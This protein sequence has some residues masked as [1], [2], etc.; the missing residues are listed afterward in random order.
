M[1]PSVDANARGDTEILHNIRRATLSSLPNRP[2]VR[3]ERRR[4]RLSVTGARHRP[5]GRAPSPRRQRQTVARISKR[6]GGVLSPE[7]KHCTHTEVASPS[8]ERAG[9][10][11]H[12]VS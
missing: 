4:R 10:K 6:A 3:V 1:S 11:R 9:S 5:D 2:G 12:E 8:S 7:T